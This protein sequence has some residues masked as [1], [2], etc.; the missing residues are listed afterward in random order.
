MSAEVETL[1]V[2]F[3]VP[4][5]NLDELDLTV[6]DHTVAVSGPEGFRHDVQL[7]LEAD[8]SALTIELYKGFLELRAPRRS[9]HTGGS[10]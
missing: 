6:L 7:P 4:C 2:T 9:G 10:R 8:M 3:G 5:N 1:V